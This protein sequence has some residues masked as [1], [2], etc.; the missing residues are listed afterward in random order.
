MDHLENE[1]CNEQITPSTVVL[2]EKAPRLSAL[3]IQS[4]RI[5]FESKA[6]ILSFC[7]E[8]SWLW[9][10]GLLGRRG[11]AYKVVGA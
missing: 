11:V 6:G 5:E 3:S 9:D 8:F 4:G 2:V 10:T 1:F 7:G